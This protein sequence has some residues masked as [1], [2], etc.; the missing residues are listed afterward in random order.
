M[1]QEELLLPNEVVRSKR[2]SISLQIKVNGEFIVRAPLNCEDKKI[3]NFIH[4]KANWIINKRLEAKAH[5]QSLKL[6][7]GENIVLLDK[8]YKIHVADTVRAKITSNLIV[9]PQ[10]NKKENLVKILKK[11]LKNYLEQ[12]VPKFANFFG[13][14]YSNI[15]VSSAKT[16]WGSCSATNRLHFT[17]K[18]ALCPKEVVDYIIIH[19]LCHTKVKNHSS[20]FWSLVFKCCPNYKTQEKWLK[21]NRAV[22]E[23]I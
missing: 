8:N 12:K 7:D 14:S 20:K 21:T 9:L 10:C 4:Q 19:E 18:L 15:G 13:F 2:K 11:V 16:N 22:V 17:Y 5:A 1:Q 6:E 3:F 23:L